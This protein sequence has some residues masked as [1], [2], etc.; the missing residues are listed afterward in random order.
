MIISRDVAEPARHDVKGFTH[1][2]KNPIYGMALLMSTAD[3]GLEP[4]EA[5]T[6]AGDHNNKRCCCSLGKYPPL[7]N[8]VIHL[9]AVKRKMLL[10]LRYCVI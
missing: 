9:N 2:R 6:H 4:T 5:T 10:V 8:F 7:K 3:F 1:Q